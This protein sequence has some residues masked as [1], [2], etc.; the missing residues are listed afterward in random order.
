MDACT[1]RAQCYNCEM[2]ELSSTT[3][4]WQSLVL[5]LGIIA[6]HSCL[7]STISSL[8]KLVAQICFGRLAQLATNSI[9]SRTIFA[10]RQAMT[11]YSNYFI[12]IAIPPTTTIITTMP[13][14]SLV[15]YMRMGLPNTVLCDALARA[16]SLA[17]VHVLSAG[18]QKQVCNHRRA[19]CGI[20]HSVHGQSMGLYNV[21]LIEDA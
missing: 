16:Y 14:L 8:K 9:A 18:L 7:Y 15:C 21:C 2:V 5:Q 4:K 19:S 12:S 17:S 10:G 20:H 13:K 11:V 6:S 3:W 1:G